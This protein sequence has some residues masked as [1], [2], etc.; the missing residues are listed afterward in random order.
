M[1][2]NNFSRRISANFSGVYRL[3]G[4]IVEF[5]QHG[6]P[7]IKLRLS[8]CDTDYIAGL[9]A[10]NET[11][12]ETIGYLDQVTVSGIECGR[13]S[14]GLDVELHDIRLASRDEVNMQ[15][16]LHSLPR[17]TLHKSR[18]SCL[19]AVGGVKSGYPVTT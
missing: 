15:P 17:E 10:D 5:D 12:P 1:K 8:S 18:H 19:T 6:S 13:N 11:M 7:Y 14:L 9:V 16:Y 2:L 4:R 3:T